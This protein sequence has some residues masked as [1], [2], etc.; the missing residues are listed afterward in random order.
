MKF[1]IKKLQR[2]IPF[3]LLIAH[4]VKL[5]FFKEATM[6][7]SAVACGLFAICGYMAYLEKTELPD[8]RKEAQEQIDEFKKVVDENFRQRD[9]FI[10]EKLS[11]MQGDLGKVSMSVAKGKVNEPFRF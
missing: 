5:L 1:S 9:A 2:F 4:S 3:I 10:N 6:A 7:D 8:I 11:K